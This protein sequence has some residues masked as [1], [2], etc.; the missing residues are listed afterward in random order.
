MNICIGFAGKTELAKRISRYLHKDG[1]KVDLILV[2]VGFL[3]MV[4]FVPEQK[5]LTEISPSFS[6]LGRPPSVLVQSKVPLELGN[7]SAR[8]VQWQE[9][10]SKA[11][12]LCCRASSELTCPNIKRNC[13]AGLHPN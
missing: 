11:K 1:E 3:K 12:T 13:V 5:L 10:N 4:L 2:F 6:A 9:Q 8:N 7:S